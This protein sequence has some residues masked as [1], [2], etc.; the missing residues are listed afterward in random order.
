MLFHQTTINARGRLVSLDTPIVMGILNV[1]PDSFHDGGRFQ[2]RRAAVSWVGDMLESGAAVIDV[3]GMSSRPGAE[4]TSPMREKERVIPVIEDLM[5]AYPEVVISIDTIH[6]AT[7]EAALQAGA[8]IV[9]DISGGRF[10]PAIIDVA[11]SFRA[12]FICMHMQGMPSDMQRDPQYVDVTQEVLEFF[13]ERIGTLRAKGVHDVIIDPGFGFGKTI[14]HNYELLARLGIL[15][16]LE[17]PLLVGL[18]RKSMVCRVLDVKPADALNG[19]TA[20]HMIALQRGADILR[21]HDVREA[22]E[23][24][25]LFKIFLA[26]G[27]NKFSGRIDTGIQEYP[28]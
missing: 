8:S 16:M 26:N 25:T 7:A 3:G 27:G 12:P 6:A 10:D 14:A 5:E 4:L 9:N 11:A 24:I 1:T 20:L 18:S 15:K 19:S 21:V 22:N 23:V 17:V 2:D 13:T 28:D